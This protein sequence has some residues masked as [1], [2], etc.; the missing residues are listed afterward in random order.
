[1]AKHIPVGIDLGTSRSLI[2]YIDALGRPRVIED[3]EDQKKLTPSI[4]MFDKEGDEIIINVGEVAKRAAVARPDNVIRFVKSHMHKKDWE[5]EDSS[6]KKWTPSTLSSLI[7]KKMKNYAEKTLRENYELPEDQ[8]L[9]HAV[10]TV[11]YYFGDLERERT[12]EAGKIAGFEV[13]SIIDEPVAAAIAF[14]LNEERTNITSLI[15]D[16]GGGTFDIAVTDVDEKG[17]IEVVAT[18]GHRSLGGAN[19]DQIICEYFKEEFQKVHNIDPL[20]DLR[21]YQDFMEKAEAAKET[22]SGKNRSVNIPLSSGGKVLDLEFTREKLEELLHPLL[23]VTINLLEETLINIKVKRDITEQSDE[24][25]VGI[26]NIKAFKEKLIKQ[27]ETEMLEKLRESKRKELNQLR[28]DASS[29][30]SKRKAW[31]Q[32]KTEEWSKIDRILLVGGST[33]IP[34]VQEILKT[35]SGKAPLTLASPDEAVALGAAAVAAWEYAKLFPDEKDLPVVCGSRGP[36]KETHVEKIVSH[37]LGVKALI[38]NTTDK[39][40]NSK[41]IYKGTKRPAEGQGLFTNAFDNQTSI[42]IQLLQ[43]E[44][45]EAEFCQPVGD[46]CLL[47]GIPP[48]PKGMASIKV[49][50]KYDGEDIIHVTALEES[51]GET[52]TFEARVQ[53]I[54][55][56]K[57]KKEIEQ[58]EVR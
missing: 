6:G 27:D 2:A 55:I 20:Q 53:P 28:E 18:H 32:I 1:M 45:D 25:K 51:S 14:G 24:F 40:I 9:T 26:E 31:E 30:T 48:M 56:E 41:I 43:G 54:D 5:W 22:L 13:M 12:K 35:H 15:Y 8:Q 19:F 58:I 21:T 4:I 37:S 10:I 3:M 17:K 47:R 42:S 57:E 52:L 34:L 49:I 23:D 11:P 50:L 39:F 29:N 36:K 44:P 33:K 38:L 16:L 46:G 7:L